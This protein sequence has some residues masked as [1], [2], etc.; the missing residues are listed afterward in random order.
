M[1]LHP[2]GVFCTHLEAPI[3]HIIKNQKCSIFYVNKVYTFLPL[4]SNAEVEQDD[5]QRGRQVQ[6]VKS[7]GYLDAALE[8]PGL[9][10][11]GRHDDTL[12]SLIS[13]VA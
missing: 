12:I 9:G 4:S 5:P 1:F 2:V 3:S 11:D 10:R 7:V 8:D 6:G 13:V